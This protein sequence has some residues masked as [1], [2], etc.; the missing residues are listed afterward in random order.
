[1]TQLLTGHD[2]SAL[3]WNIHTFTFCKQVWLWRFSYDAKHFE[4]HIF[5]MSNTVRRQTNKQKI[6]KQTYKYYNKW[7]QKK[8]N[9]PLIDLKIIDFSINPTF[10]MKTS[11]YQVIIRCHKILYGF[12]GKLFDHII[13]KS[14]RKYIKT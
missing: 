3:L 6:N 13:I 10:N 8:G 7:S 2:I 11:E 9:S 4:R 14:I 1:M 12:V 5:I